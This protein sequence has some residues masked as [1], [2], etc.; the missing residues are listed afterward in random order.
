MIAS[1]SCNK[2]SGRH[3]GTST[4]VEE[5][6]GHPLQHIYCFFHTIDGVGKKFFMLLEGPT[7]GP[8]SVKGPIGL[9]LIGDKIH[10]TANEDF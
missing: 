7:D 2:N 3:G 10:M 5:L 6:V 4:L 8:E 1:D 9:A